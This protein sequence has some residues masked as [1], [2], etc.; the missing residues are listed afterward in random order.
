MAVALILLVL[1]VFS[2]NK[3]TF[4]SINVLL[5]LEVMYFSIL[6]QR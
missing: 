1:Y 2:L 5:L 4:D 3:N 6:Q